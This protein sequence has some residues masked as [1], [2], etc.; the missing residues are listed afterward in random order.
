MIVSIH[1]N[2]F[3]KCEDIKNSI[4]F[5]YPHIDINI[6]NKIT[7]KIKK[8]DYIVI[9]NNEIK[10]YSKK[11]Y[12]SINDIDFW[13]EDNVLLESVKT[14]IKY[15]MNSNVLVINNDK[16]W[17]IFKNNLEI[18]NINYLEINNNLIHSLYFLITDNI[19]QISYQNFW[20]I[21]KQIKRITIKEYLRYIKLKQLL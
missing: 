10:H 13:V 6:I 8:Y 21:E 18:K 17:V 14:I 16:D 5:L 7:N 12:E 19:H 1:I 9:N 2:N 3:S 15:K 11:E 20:L 4:H